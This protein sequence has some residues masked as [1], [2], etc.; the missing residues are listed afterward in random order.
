MARRYRRY[1]YRKDESLESIFEKLLTFVFLVGVLYLLAQ[2]FTNRANFWRSVIYIAVALGIIIFGLLTWKRLKEKRKHYHVE[3]VMAKIKERGL[4]NNVKSFIKQFGSGLMDKSHDWEYAGYNF[5]YKQLDYFRDFLKDKGVELDYS[6]VRVVLRHYID[7]LEGDFI[8]KMISTPESSLNK[9]F[10]DLSGT[11]FEVLLERLFA[12][13]GYIVKRTG[14][15]GDQGV[16]LVAIKGDEK[17]AIQAKKRLAD[18]S[19]GNDAI[20]QV[21]SGKD[22]YSCNEAVIITTSANL[23]K[24]VK[25][26]AKTLGVKLVHRPLL[27][28]MLLEHLGESWS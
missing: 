26:A 28:K 10:D 17:L 22:M 16:D 14:R 11:D 5:S 19:L 9:K 24:E 25:E 18:E 1:H 23:T 2:Y 13:M 15:T 20:Q 27:Q 8:S 3:S 7:E 21:F 4:E 6:D 12:K